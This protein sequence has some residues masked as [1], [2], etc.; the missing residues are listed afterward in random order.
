M[1]FGCLWGE[2]VEL[3]ENASLVSSGDTICV[4]DWLNITGKP[5]LPAR[6]KRKWT[7]T[8]IL[9]EMEVVT[10]FFHYHKTKVNKYAKI[11]I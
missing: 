8:R 2:H 5:S 1:S 4:R 11:K 7:S 6:E 9:N 3:N 10:S